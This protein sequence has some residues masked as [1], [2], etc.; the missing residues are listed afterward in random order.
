MTI[1]TRYDAFR[2]AFAEAPITLTTSA[3]FA[4]GMDNDSIALAS[5]TF[6]GVTADMSLSV[7]G[8]A[9]NDFGA[10]RIDRFNVTKTT[11]LITEA[12]LLTAEGPVSVEI[13]ARYLDLMYLP[14]WPGPFA[15]GS[16]L[17][18]ANGFDQGIQITSGL[19]Y[20]GGTIVCTVNGEAADASPGVDEYDWYLSQRTDDA[21]K[22]FL[23]I[24]NKPM[25]GMS[26]YSG[27]VQLTHT[28]AAEN[29]VGADFGASTGMVTSDHRKRLLNFCHLYCRRRSDGAIQWLDLLLAASDV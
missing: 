1:L 24:I 15:L 20:G 22:Q 27:T 6:S 28:V 17:V 18:R 23:T 16:N 7:V 8:S 26:T 25:V 4:V 9:N 21:D 29:S 2:I 19:P 10:L 12:G 5:G 14:E 13:Q 11:A 3:T